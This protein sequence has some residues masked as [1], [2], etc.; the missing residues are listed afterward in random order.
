MSMFNVFYTAGYYSQSHRR[1]AGEW[2]AFMQN[3][4]NALVGRGIAAAAA[5]EWVVSFGKRHRKTEPAIDFWQAAESVA[6]ETDNEAIIA[7]S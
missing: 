1:R 2:L 5:A 3:A 4:I 7:R 6:G